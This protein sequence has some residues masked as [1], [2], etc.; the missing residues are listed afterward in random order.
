MISS[1]IS[2]AIVS[3]CG[4][5]DIINRERDKTQ[6]SEL[7]IVDGKERMIIAGSTKLEE[8]G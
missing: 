8:T 7:M 6:G 2:V 1:S 4:G 5:V 3:D